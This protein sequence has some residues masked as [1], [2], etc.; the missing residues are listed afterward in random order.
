[1]DGCCRPSLPC[2]P[3]CCA[4]EGPGPFF[5]LDA[6]LLE[7]GPDS[8][9]LSLAANR[10]LSLSLPII[11]PPCSPTRPGPIRRATDGTSPNIRSQRAEPFKRRWSSPLGQLSFSLPSF[12]TL[13]PS[14]STPHPLFL[15]TMLSS[16]LL[17]IASAA[18]VVLPF[19]APVE[20]SCAHGIAG[21][22]PFERRGHTDEHVLHPPKFGYDIEDGPLN[23]HTLA[24][25]NAMC[26]EGTHVRPPCFVR[27]S[28]IGCAPK[29]T[30]G[31]SC[32]SSAISHHRPDGEP[33]GR[34][35]GRGQALDAL[36]PD[37]RVHEQPR[38]DRSVGPSPCTSHWQHLLL[39]PLRPASPS[40]SRCC[41]TARSGPE[42]SRSRWSTPTSTLPPSTGSTSLTTRR[43]CTWSSRTP[44][45]RSLRLKLLAMLA[46]TVLHSP[47]HVNPQTRRSPSSP[48]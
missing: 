43:R 48:S 9:G 23:W 1:M 11:T 42:T 25:E 35:Q 19:L 33:P 12:L 13:S 26:A 36:K 2:L 38:H 14:S 24:P 45:V 20:A 3:P 29:L 31:R 39:I 21:I 15:P 16:P 27:G 18:S 22:H 6:S 41:S 5:R 46:L 30:V 40:Q 28:C 7:L 4:Q 47:L 17:L 37:G 44:T 10:A 8:Q 32:F 34:R